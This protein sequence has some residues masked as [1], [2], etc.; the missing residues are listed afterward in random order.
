[1]LS[2]KRQVVHG[3]ISREDIHPE[4]VCRTVETGLG[5]FC[6]Y[7]YRRMTDDELAAFAFA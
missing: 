1:M 6:F 2:I 5:V 4:S 3:I 7:P